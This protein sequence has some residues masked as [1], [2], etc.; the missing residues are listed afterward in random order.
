[1]L[2]TLWIYVL[3]SLNSRK[4]DTGADDIS[5]RRGIGSFML[6][7][8]FHFPTGCP[9][10]G[11][12]ISRQLTLFVVVSLVFRVDGFIRWI[13]LPVATPIRIPHELRLETQKET[14]K[15]CAD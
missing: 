7:L 9:L 13:V 10:I 4:V 5:A 1:M 8:G 12:S 3:R 11:T 14:H 15:V 2:E 6:I